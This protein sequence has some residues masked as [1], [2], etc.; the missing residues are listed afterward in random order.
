[1]EFQQLRIACPGNSTVSWSMPTLTQ[2]ACTPTSSGS[3]C[4]R[5][6]R[7]S[8]LKSPTSSFFFTPVGFRPPFVTPATAHSYADRGGVLILIGAPPPRRRHAD[9]STFLPPPA[10]QATPAAPTVHP[11]HRRL[12]T[13]TA[14]A[15]TAIPW[16]QAGN[17]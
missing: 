5:H 11:D 13:R 15:S 12:Q 9:E 6:S 2:P 10:R 7:P 8:F 3:P 16:L 4:G 17:Q 14:P 1:M